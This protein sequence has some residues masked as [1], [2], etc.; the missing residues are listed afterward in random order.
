MAEMLFSSDK[1]MDTAQLKSQQHKDFSHEA[2]LDHK[3]VIQSLGRHKKLSH[4]ALL[5]HMDVL[6]ELNTHKNM[7]HEAPKHHEAL[8]Q[9]KGIIENLKTHKNASHEA[10]LDHKVQIESTQDCIEQIENHIGSVDDGLYL[11]TEA[12]SQLEQKTEKTDSYVKTLLQ[13][14]ESLEQRMLRL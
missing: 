4:E 3:S 2:L 11:N 9:H 7:S 13:N 5:D 12:I 14:V 8:L 6:Q 1:L 10:L